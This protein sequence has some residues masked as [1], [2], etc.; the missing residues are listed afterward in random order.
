[1][2]DHS[3]L[4]VLTKVSQSV[5]YTL[6]HEKTSDALGELRSARILLDGPVWTLRSLVAKACSALPSGWQATQLPGRVILYREQEGDYPR[7]E[8]IARS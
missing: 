3:V 6:R 4:E 1:M 2:G 5:P 8:V 7:A